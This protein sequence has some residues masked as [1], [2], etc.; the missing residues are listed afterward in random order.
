MMRRLVWTFWLA[1]ILSVVG[2]F[3][4]S[5]FL[6]KQWNKFVSYSEIIEPTNYPFRILSKE[7]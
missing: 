1:L 5:A 7:N 4:V 2:T 3:V 6:I